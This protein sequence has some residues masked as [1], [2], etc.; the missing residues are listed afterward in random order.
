MGKL[1]NSLHRTLDRE[2]KLLLASGLL[3]S[4]ERR[5]TREL[6]HK[7]LKCY[8][9]LIDILEDADTARDVAA[10]IRRPLS[11]VQSAAGAIID[12]LLFNEEADPSVSLG[13]PGNADKTEAHRRWKRLLLHYHPDRYPDSHEYEK[14]AKKINEA[15]EQLQRGQGKDWHSPVDQPLNQHALH[16]ADH[17]SSVRVMRNVPVF[18]LALAL[19]A[20]I[21]SL[22]LF[23]SV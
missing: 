2:F 13:L 18:I 15:Y 8:E 12:L 16:A 20:C 5:T 10:L 19:F 1:Q 6:Y 9:I 4:Y 23:I 14:K 3:C 21:I 11:S 7:A 17:A 22:W